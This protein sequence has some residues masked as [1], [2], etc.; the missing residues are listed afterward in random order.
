MGLA[1]GLVAFLPSYN[2]IGIWAPIL[3]VIL[4]L[5]QGSR[6]AVNGVALLRS[7]SNTLP[8]GSAGLSAACTKSPPKSAT[9]LASCLPRCLRLLHNRNFQEWGWRIAFLFGALLAPVGYYLR[10]R[11]AETPVFVQAEARKAVASSPLRVIF[12]QHRA[13]VIAGICIAAIAA[14][15]QLRSRFMSAN[16]PAAAET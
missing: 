15:D 3:L 16:L 10:T 11:V 2:S 8:P 1:T 4:R 14:T 12:T 9:S 13:L 7:S 6:R 5:A